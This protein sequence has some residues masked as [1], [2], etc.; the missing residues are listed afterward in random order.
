MKMPS[1]TN[2]QAQVKEAQSEHTNPQDGPGWNQVVW[3]SQQNFPHLVHE[4]V[5]GAPHE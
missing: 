3:L 5:A 2:H 4:R 1:A